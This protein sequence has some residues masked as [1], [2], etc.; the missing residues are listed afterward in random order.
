M[1]KLVKRMVKNAEQL[2]SPVRTF[3]FRCYT[4]INK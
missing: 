1:E 2:S 3:L 4:W